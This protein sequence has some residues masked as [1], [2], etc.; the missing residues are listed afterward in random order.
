MFMP[1]DFKPV[2][3]VQQ[4]AYKKWNI[5]T[6]E[7][8]ADKLA[9]SLRRGTA[10]TIWLYASTNHKADH[11]KVVADALDTTIDKLFYGEK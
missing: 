1:I 4:L 11:L 3:K 5:E 2:N 7:G 8:F 10:R 6:A 9:P